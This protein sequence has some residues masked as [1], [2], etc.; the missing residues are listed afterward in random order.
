M[1]EKRRGKAAP[2]RQLGSLQRR[3][4]V[5]I[6]D[7]MSELYTLQ[8]CG[9]KRRFQEI[10][11]CEERLKVLNQKGTPWSA[12]AFYGYAPSRSEEATLSGSL[13]SLEVKGLV[14]LY[15][16]TNGLGYKK[17]TTHV[18]LTQLGQENAAFLKNSGGKSQREL[19]KERRQAVWHI[20]DHMHR[21]KGD[22][23]FEKERLKRV[24]AQQEWNRPL[25]EVETT[26]EL[27]EV[28]M[29]VSILEERL[30]GWEHVLASPNCEEFEATLREGLASLFSE[31]S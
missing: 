21:L 19:E 13:T 17:R 3:V 10:K 2:G 28:A 20:R 24:Y 5:W 29:R 16:A 11:G 4:L 31:I 6:Y 27:Y 25:A 1:T 18:K 8:R 7:N 23:K 12:K 14:V 26:S 22:L 9:G 30:A 15:D